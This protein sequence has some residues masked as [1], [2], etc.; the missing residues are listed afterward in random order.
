MLHMGYVLEIRSL[1]RNS[2]IIIR[3]KCIT[4]VMGH[5]FFYVLYITAVKNAVAVDV[6]TFHFTNHLGTI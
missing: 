3:S 2:L 4:S 1:E 5:M 6:S